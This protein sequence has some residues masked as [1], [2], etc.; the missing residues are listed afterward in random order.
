MAIARGFGSGDNFNGPWHLVHGNL[1][2]DKTREFRHFWP[3]S[4]AIAHGF[5]SGDD[6]N[7]PSPPVHSNL[8]VAKTR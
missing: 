3:F 7:G 6:F 4:W 5:G 2:V 8:E 1:E